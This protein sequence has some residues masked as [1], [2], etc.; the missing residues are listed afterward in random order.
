MAE[1]VVK[2]VAQKTQHHFTLWKQSPVGAQRIASCFFDRDVPLS[3]TF[4]QEERLG[5]GNSLAPNVAQRAGCAIVEVFRQRFG[6]EEEVLFN[7]PLDPTSNVCVPYSA[8]GALTW[9][10]G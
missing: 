9:R 7:K 2:T 5:F 3:L 10:S 8:R 4:S 1:K 6:A